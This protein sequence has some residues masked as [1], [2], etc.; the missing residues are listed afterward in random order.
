MDLFEQGRQVPGTECWVDDRARIAFTA[1]TRTRRHRRRC[2]SC[3]TR[4]RCTPGRHPS[5]PRAKGQRLCIPLK[6]LRRGL[7][8]TGHRLPSS[9]ARTALRKAR[10]T[11]SSSLCCASGPTAGPIRTPRTNSR[12]ASA[13][14]IGGSGTL[15]IRSSTLPA[16]ASV[17]R[18]LMHPCSASATCCAPMVMNE[19]SS[20]PPARSCPSG[21]PPLQGTCVMRASN[22]CAKCSASTWYS[23]PTPTLP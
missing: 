5:A 10:P 16:G 19:T 7:R 1:T 14:D 12:A 17:P 20:T 2:S 4:W 15:P 9:A 18:I 21:A 11:A 3:K 6:G 23:E 13:S 8:R 22:F